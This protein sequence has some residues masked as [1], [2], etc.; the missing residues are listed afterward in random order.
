MMRYNNDIWK[1]V[2]DCDDFKIIENKS[3]YAI[4]PKHNKIGVGII[5]NDGICCRPDEFIDAMWIDKCEKKYDDNIY[6]KISLDD[7]KDLQDLIA[8]K[9]Q[10][11]GHVIEVELK[12]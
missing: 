1:S 2:Y 6:V 12:K 9:I 3:R 7:I 11:G 10:D 5:G 8:D 4:K